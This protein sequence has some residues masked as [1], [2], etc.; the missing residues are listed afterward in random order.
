MPDQQPLQRLN[1]DFKEVAEAG[2][3][4]DANFAIITHSHAEFCGLCKRYVRTPKSK[5]R[6]ILIPC[7]LLFFKKGWK[8]M[9]YGMRLPMAHP[10]SEQVEIC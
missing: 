2:Q 9:L 10:G 4:G 1:I 3:F 8:I 6:I 7:M 5:S